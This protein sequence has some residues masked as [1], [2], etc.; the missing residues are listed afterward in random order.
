MSQPKTL[1]LSLGGM[2]LPHPTAITLNLTAKNKHRVRQEYKE[3]HRAARSIYEKQL[4][5]DWT[6]YS[7]A[8]KVSIRLLRPCTCPSRSNSDEHWDRNQMDPRGGSYGGSLWYYIKSLHDTLWPE[9]IVDDE[10]IAECQTESI[11]S[12]LVNEHTAI[13]TIETLDVIGN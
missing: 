13:L 12:S 11:C 2:I 7:S 3:F 8:L 5:D 10:F 6:P 4:P 9:V 1:K